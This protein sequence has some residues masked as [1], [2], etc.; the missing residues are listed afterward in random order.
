MCSDSTVAGIQVNERLNVSG[1]GI[2]G[3]VYTTVQELKEQ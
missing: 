3:G 2:D 1:S